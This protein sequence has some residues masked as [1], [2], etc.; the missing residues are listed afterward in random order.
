MNVTRTV[1]LLVAALTTLALS[2]CGGAAQSPAAGGGAASAEH[3]EADIAFVQGMIPHHSQAV[4]MAQLAP[5]RAASSQVK[6][7]AAQ[8]EQAQAPEIEQMRGFLAAWG[9]KEEAGSMGGMD[10]GGSGGMTGMMS[11]AQMQQLEQATGAA[12]DRLFLQQ[13]TEHHTGAVQMARTELSGG[14]NAQAKVLA[15]MIIDTQ[16]A[17]IEQMNKLLT[18]V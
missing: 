2:A 9:V 11:D 5:A 4:E 14:Q 18:T 15:Q 3:N 17:E 7:L 8:I 13:M 6:E 1:G 12:F 10:H 16:S